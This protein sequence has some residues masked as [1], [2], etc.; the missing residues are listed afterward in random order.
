MIIERT[1]GLVFCPY[2]ILY[3]PVLIQSI[4]ANKAMWTTQALFKSHKRR[5][6]PDSRSSFY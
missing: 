6:G 2:A 5:Q 3:I 4:V 1:K